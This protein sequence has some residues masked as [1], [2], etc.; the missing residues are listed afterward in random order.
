MGLLFGY[1]IAAMIVRCNVSGF[2]SAVV[3]R[4]GLKTEAQYIKGRTTW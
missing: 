2:F 1:G 4:A 3:A